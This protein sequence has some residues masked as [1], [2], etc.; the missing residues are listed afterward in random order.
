MSRFLE[1]KHT[2][3]K[4]AGTQIAKE[5]GSSDSTSR[6]HR[7]DEK[8]KI[9]IDPQKFKM[10]SKELK[11]PQK[12]LAKHSMETSSEPAISPVRTVLSV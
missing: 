8:S 10:A 7:K 9:L 6:R 1:I 4:I 2:T 3:P 11:R 12:K 5:L